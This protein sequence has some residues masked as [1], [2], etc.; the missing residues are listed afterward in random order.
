M[1]YIVGMENNIMHPPAT[2][3]RQL[4]WDPD[5]REYSGEIS[6]THGFGRVYADACDEG[7]TL[8]SNK[9]GRSVVFA[10]QHVERDAEGDT[11]YWVLIPASR[12]DRGL[13]VTVILFN[14]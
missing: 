9:T 6:S 14:D 3:V 13:D 8:V 2:N 10:V 4:H 5:R 1:G 12:E 7:L 11:L